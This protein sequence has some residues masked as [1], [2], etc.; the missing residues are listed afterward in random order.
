MPSECQS[1][2]TTV[3]RVQQMPPMSAIDTHLEMLQSVLHE[4]GLAFSISSEI[5]WKTLYSY[6]LDTQLRLVNALEKYVSSISNIQADGIRFNES[7]KALWHLFVQNR[8]RLDDQIFSEIDESDVVEVY[9]ADGTQF[10]RNFNYFQYSSYTLADLIFCPWEELIEHES[11]SRA[12]LI[13]ISKRIFGGNASPKERFKLAPYVARERFS[14][15]RFTAELKSKFIC[16][17]RGRLT[18]NN[19][20]ALV[21]WSIRLVDEPA[22]R[23]NNLYVID[24]TI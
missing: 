16:P 19:E 14:E 13:D 7:K 9:L 24:A 1:E 17:I 18:G 8:W 22:L 2:I 6:P 5:A 10:F 21:V 3:T 11:N 20:A 4:N 15:Q 23:T 12:E